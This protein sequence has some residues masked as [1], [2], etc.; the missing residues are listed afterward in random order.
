MT[1]PKGVSFKTDRQTK[2]FRVWL[3]KQEGFD[4]EGEA[5]KARDAYQ[6]AKVEA[7]K[8]SRAPHVE[9]RAQNVMTYG[10]GLT[11]ERDVA[12]ALVA[13]WR[14]TGLPALVLN[15]ST[16]ADVLLGL[17]KEDEEDQDAWLPVQLKTTGSAQMIWSS[18]KTGN[19]WRFKNVTGYS[20]MAVVCWR[21]DIQDGWVYDGGKL[22]E[23]GVDSISIT[24]NSKNCNDA[25][26]RHLDL[27]QLVLWLHT[28]AN[29]WRTVTEYAARHDFASEAHAIE[30][31]G[32]DAF[33]ALF[34]EHQYDF[35]EGQ[36]SHV[37]LLQGEKRL[38]FKTVSEASA[39]KAGFACILTTS[40]GIV[41]GKK[42]KKPYPV[43]AFD[44]L[45][46]VAWVNDTAH[47]W[48]VPAAELETR[49]VLR[50]DSQEGKTGLM[51]HA[52][53][54]GVQP[55]SRA[56]VKADTWTAGYFIE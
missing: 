52:P 22:D 3:G 10:Q 20:G 6:A 17:R 18:Q 35:P 27:D 48:R 38:Q 44:Y 16:K 36:N 40:A 37:D 47:F 26:A 13:A 43:G 46:A 7:K 8:A 55:N 56:S 49:G 9:E 53:T 12:L 15:D 21:C 11:Q 28:N 32:M 24:P 41:E 34:P 54:I 4:T 5:V 39:D 45:V 23:H 30:M 51:L 25:L 14:A 31:R 50:S 29:Q 2:Q 1:L 42:T 19:K 33:K